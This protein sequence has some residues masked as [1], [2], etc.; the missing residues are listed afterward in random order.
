[1]QHG[2]AKLAFSE[3]LLWSERKDR[4]EGSTLWPPAV[5]HQVKR[6]VED[7][8]PRAHSGNRQTHGAPEGW[9]SD[10]P[11]AQRGRCAAVRLPPSGWRG[12]V[13]TQPRT[14]VEIFTQQDQTRHGYAEPHLIT[15][16]WANSATG[17]E[18]PGAHSVCRSA[19]PENRPCRR[20]C[21]CGA[22]Q[23]Q[24]GEEEPGGCRTLV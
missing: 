18:M 17:M 22:T 3:P 11:A 9:R 19:S 1:M 16:R 7:R 24:E 13:C 5:S 23:G 15:V 2:R 4:P 10:G 20:A 12:A 14:A 21:T 6:Q 8:R